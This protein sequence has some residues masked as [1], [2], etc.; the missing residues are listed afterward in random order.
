MLNRQSSA[1]ILA[2]GLGNRLKPLTDD[3][4]KCLVEFLGKPFLIR[5]I[6]QL[7]LVQV[8][9]ITI[10]CGYLSNVLRKFCGKEVNGI[11]IEY[12]EN[13]NYANTNSM[14]SL[15]LAREKLSK[16]CYLIEGDTVCNQELITSLSQLGTENSFWAGRS[17]SGEFD[18][19]ILSVDPKSRCIVKQEIERNPIPGPKPNQY[20]STGILSISAEYGQELSTWLDSD[21]QAGNINIYYDLVIGKHLSDKPIYIFDIGKELWFEVDT[22]ED[23]HKAE[24]IFK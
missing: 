10:V 15:W 6:E 19:C 2:A 3:K 17:Y 23:L 21:V 4:P 20:K 9:N 18:G 12:I 5:M 7:S 14:Y 1:I 22:V 24:Q 8:E 13:F 11:K 16:G